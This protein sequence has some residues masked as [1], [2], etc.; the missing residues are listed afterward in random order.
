[1]KARYTMRI[2]IFFLN[3]IYDIFKINYDRDI[4]ITSAKNLFQTR[5]LAHVEMMSGL[6]AAVRSGDC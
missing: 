2:Y 6:R 3:Q 1:M 4:G 5:F